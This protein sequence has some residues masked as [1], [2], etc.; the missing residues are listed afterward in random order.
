VGVR[1]DGW[2][3]LFGHAVL[4]GPLRHRTGGVDE[5]LSVLAS[6]CKGEVVCA[7]CAKFPGE[8]LLHQSHTSAMYVLRVA[9]SNVG[10][11]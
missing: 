7:K 4:I 1:R 10:H 8:P 2:V 6:S 5:D 9:L 3:C 11:G